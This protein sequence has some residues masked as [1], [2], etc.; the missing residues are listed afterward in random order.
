MR[1]LAPLL[2]SIA[3]I[4][5]EGLTAE[6]KRRLLLAAVFAVFGAIAAIFLLIALYMA[7]ADVWGPTYAALAIAGAAIVAIVI[8]YIVNLVGEQAW[9]RQEAEARRKR[10]ANAVMTTAALGVVPALLRTRFAIPAAAIGA[11]LL[12]RGR[13]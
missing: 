7:L 5:L 1:L 2:A 13:K 3:G 4:E 11:Y 8:A 12:F 10:E 6:I 9:K